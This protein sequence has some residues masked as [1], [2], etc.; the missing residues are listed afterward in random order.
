MGL[1]VMIQVVRKLIRMPANSGGRRR[2]KVVMP[3][4]SVRH[5]TDL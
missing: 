1:L 4:G 2:V 5:F 3:S